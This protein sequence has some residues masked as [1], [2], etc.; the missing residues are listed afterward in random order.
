MMSD[1]KSTAVVRLLIRKMGSREYLGV[2]NH[3]TSWK[4]GKILDTDFG[5]TFSPT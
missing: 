3:D 4:I 1:L 5:L 2:R